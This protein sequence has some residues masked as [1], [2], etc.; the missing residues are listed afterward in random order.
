[1]GIHSSLTELWNFQ[2]QLGDKGERLIYL[3][4]NHEFAAADA[5]A[6]LKRQGMTARSQEHFIRA[7][8]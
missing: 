1:M 8:I 7:F 6:M 3:R 5:Y 4:G 2:K